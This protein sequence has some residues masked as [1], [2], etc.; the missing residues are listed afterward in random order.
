MSKGLGEYYMRPGGSGSFCCETFQAKFQPVGCP[1]DAAAAGGAQQ[2]DVRH[3]GSTFTGSGSSNILGT[4]YVGDGST[5]SFF[6]LFSYVCPI[7]MRT[8]I[9]GGR[10]KLH[11]LCRAEQSV[12]T[13]RVGRAAIRR[14]VETGPDTVRGRKEN[15]RDGTR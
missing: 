4:A 5:N 10:H 7:H 8:L 9:V 2:K 1:G 15:G 6:E 11:A 14:V 3:A 12:K 13:H